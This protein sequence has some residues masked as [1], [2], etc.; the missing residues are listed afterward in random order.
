MK[1][2]ELRLKNLLMFKGVVW[3]VTSIPDDDYYFQDHEP[4]PLTEE[5]LDK[6]GGQRLPFKTILN[7]IIFPLGRNRILSCGAIGTPNEMIWI[8]ELNKENPNKINDLVCIHNYDYDAYMPVHR[9]Q[10][11]YSD[12]ARKELELKQ[13]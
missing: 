7:S 10:N 8:C 1:A 3:D 9:F 12:L 4:I 11:L 2:N 6:L 5:W 13:A